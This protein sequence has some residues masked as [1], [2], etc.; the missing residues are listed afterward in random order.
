MNWCLFWAHIPL[1]PC[2]LTEW[3]T[4]G[5]GSPK[6]SLLNTDSSVPLGMILRSTFKVSPQCAYDRR[7]WSC[8]ESSQVTQTLTSLNL[9]NYEVVAS[10]PVHD[11]KGHIIN[12]ITELPFVLPEGNTTSQCNHLIS[13]CLAKEKKSEAD[14]RRIIIQNF[15]L[16]KDL[17]CSKSTDLSA[18]NNQNWR[19]VVFKRKRGLPDSYFNCTTAGCIWS[20]VWKFFLHLSKSLGPEYMWPAMRKGTSW[21]IFN[22]LIIA[23]MWG[24]L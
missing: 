12:L 1:V 2:W 3:V 16:L 10:E 4:I 21:D 11:L 18:N 7:P 6:R 5:F 8:F 22:F 24:R 9:H 15:L 23:K 14:L 20:Y 19:N 17:D 13:S